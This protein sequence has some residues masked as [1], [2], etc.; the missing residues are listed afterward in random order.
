M[1]ESLLTILPKP[2]VELIQRE[3]MDPQGNR[4]ALIDYVV[5]DALTYGFDP[6]ETVPCLHAAYY[7]YE[8]TAWP[9]EWDE[10]Q[11]LLFVFVSA[12]RAALKLLSYG[13]YKATLTESGWMKYEQNKK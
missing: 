10:E 2:I 5:E 3:R 11:K 1:K 7:V 12:Y 8:S 9:K 4:K 6:E 13:K